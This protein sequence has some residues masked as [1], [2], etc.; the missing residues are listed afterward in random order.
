M[1]QSWMMTTMSD[2]LFPRK[3]AQGSPSNAP[4]AFNPPS[5]P[6][7]CHWTTVSTGEQ[8]HGSSAEEQ[9]PMRQSRQQKA[10]ERTMRM[11][12]CACVSSTEKDFGELFNIKTNIDPEDPAFKC[13]FS[14]PFIRVPS[15]NLGAMR[16]PATSHRQQWKGFAPTTREPSR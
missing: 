13:S 7:C 10:S 6:A 12:A 4:A 14:A 3:H 16:Q 8:L 11:D 2:S 5:C 1:S 9:Q 15:Y